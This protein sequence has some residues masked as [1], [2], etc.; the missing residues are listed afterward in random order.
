[1]TTYAGSGGCEPAN[2]SAGG[3]GWWPR[4]E[5]DG[6][7]A[8]DDRPSAG[9]M[10][11]LAPGVRVEVRNRLDGRWSRGFE[12]IATDDDDRYRLRRLSDGGELPVPFPL[13]EV[14]TERKRGTWWY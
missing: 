4:V 7:T 13:S 6:V 3:A 5:N 10:A 11:V 12:V 9:A 8:P 2:G 14:R 1:M